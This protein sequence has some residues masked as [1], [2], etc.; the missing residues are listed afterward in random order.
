MKKNICCPVQS[1]HRAILFSRISTDKYR[2]SNRGFSLLELIISVAILALLI[3]LTAPF[4]QGTIEDSRVAKG[5]SLVDTVKKAGLRFRFDTNLW[6]VEDGVASAN[7]FE[8]VGMPSSW[9]G[10]YVESPL[11][12]IKNPWVA[13][14]VLQNT[15]SGSVVGGAG[16]NING[17][18]IP[19][20]QAGGQLVF[21]TVP[22]MSAAALNLALDG[23]ADANPSDGDGVGQCEYDVPLNGATTV[24]VWLY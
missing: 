2:M 16:Y 22:M 1:L 3:G 18:I 6:P 15:C 12:P 21:S 19:A 20:T 4:F 10:P 11:G 24:Y 8:S 9:H 5:L 13:P 14:V 7:L 23:V 17:N